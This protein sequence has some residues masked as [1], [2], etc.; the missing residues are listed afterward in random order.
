MFSKTDFQNWG[1]DNAIL[2]AAVM[3]KIDG[4][5]EDDLLRKYGFRGFPS[6]AIL[7]SSG[8]IIT[9]NVQRTLESMSA[10]VEKST[11]HLAMK[12]KVESGE[13]YDEAAWF[14]SR[15]DMG[16]IDLATA[17]TEMADLDLTPAQ[18]T[19]AK[20]QI[21]GM[22]LTKMRDAVTAQMRARGRRGAARD[23]GSTD[24]EPKLDPQA[25]V[26][27]AFKKGHRLPAG[28]PLTAYMDSLLVAAS[29]KH[30]DNE[31]LMFAYERVRKSQEA[32]VKQ[33]ESMKARYA[34][35][36]NDRARSTL[37]RIEDIIENTK[38]MIADL[39]ARAAAA[40]DK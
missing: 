15:L 26:Y 6:L 33:M 13:G 35:Q 36:D 7:D 25:F 27:E 1:K 39:D 24:E 29:K 10:I 30:D 34:N 12:K 14:L 2:F 38:K 22:E 23:D 40:K 19:S 9:K 28:H 18:K 21:F 11:K 31:A 8:K 20:Q 37:E 32:R 5:A 4:R 16:T 17:K 3:T